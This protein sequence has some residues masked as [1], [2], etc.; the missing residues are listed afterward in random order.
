MGLCPEV[1]RLGREAD[2][3]PPSKADVKNVWSCTSTSTYIFMT[4]YLVKH[5]DKR[6]FTFWV[7][8]DTPRL[9]NDLGRDV[10]YFCASPRLGV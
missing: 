7:G 9:I 1:K 10:F 5:R 6:D 4:W 2:H 3:I 8:N